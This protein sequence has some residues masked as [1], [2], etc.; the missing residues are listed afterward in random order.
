V[1][2]NAEDKILNKNSHQFKI[3]FTKDIGGI[4]G[5]KLDDH[6]IA[7]CPQSVPVKEV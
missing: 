5:E 3:R 6:L 7:N 1:L 2:F 4:F